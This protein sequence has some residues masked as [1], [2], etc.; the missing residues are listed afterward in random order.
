[1]RLGALEFLCVVLIGA[2]VYCFLK[3]IATSNALEAYMFW[4]ESKGIE[5][6]TKDEF[7]A[8][9]KEVIRQRFK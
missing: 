9:C 4:V 7:E 8:C 1:M 2:T 5:H 6:P 3:F